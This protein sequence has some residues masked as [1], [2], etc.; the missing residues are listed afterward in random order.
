M[1]YQKFYFFNFLLRN[2]EGLIK[3]QLSIKLMYI[4]IVFVEKWGHMLLKCLSCKK[5]LRKIS[6]VIFL[7]NFMK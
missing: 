1:H 2:K 6:S 4:I 5:N 3:E 7:K